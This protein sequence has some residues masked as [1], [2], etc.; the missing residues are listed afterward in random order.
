MHDETP[1]R[2][3]LEDILREFNKWDEVSDLDIYAI[4]KAIN[5]ERWDKKI[6]NCIKKFLKIDIK[7]YVSVS[8]LQEKEK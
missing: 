5:D 7:K 3:E 1:E 8:R 4:E 2:Q 6:I